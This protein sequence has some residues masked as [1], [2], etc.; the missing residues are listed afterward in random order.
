VENLGL[1]ETSEIVKNNNALAC[2]Y[3]AKNDLSK[4]GSDIPQLDE[5]IKI[6]KEFVTKKETEK[7]ESKE[8]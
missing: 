1:H 4:M 2:L 8:E 3:A 6:A 7:V 5:A